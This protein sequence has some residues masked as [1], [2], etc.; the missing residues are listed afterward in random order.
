MPVNIKEQAGPCCLQRIAMASEIGVI[1]G[2]RNIIVPMEDEKGAKNAGAGQLDFDPK[3]EEA[4]GENQRWIE[5]I[6]PNGSVALVLSRGSDEPQSEAREELRESPMFF[7]C[8]DIQQTYNDLTKRGARFP[9]PPVKMSFGWLAMF[10]DD[11]GR[12]YALGQW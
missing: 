1:S 7:N 8:E 9:A 12:R 2:I 10:E 5:V 4:F 6:P 3:L 11:E